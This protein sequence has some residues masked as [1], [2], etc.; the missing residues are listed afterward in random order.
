MRKK[1]TFKFF[2]ILKSFSLLTLANFL[3]KQGLM[4]G[5]KLFICGTMIKKI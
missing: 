4:K 2:E 5:D 3:T 1:I